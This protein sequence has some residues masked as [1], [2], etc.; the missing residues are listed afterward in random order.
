MKEHLKVHLWGGPRNIPWLYINIKK[1]HQCCSLEVKTKLVLY[2]LVTICT[3]LHYN[4]YSSSA[5]FLLPFCFSP[6]ILPSYLLLSATYK[7][8]S[9]PTKERSWWEERLTPPP[10]TYIAPTI[11]SDVEETDAVMTEQVREAIT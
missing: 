7:R 4:S 10:G 11:I 5:L 2:S 1:N 3:S 9:S 8:C 6:L